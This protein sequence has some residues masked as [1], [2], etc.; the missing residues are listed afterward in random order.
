MSAFC[1]ALCILTLSTII[2]ITN[3][4]RHCSARSKSTAPASLMPLMDQILKRNSAPAPNT[5]SPPPS[6]PVGA[7]KAASGPG[8]REMRSILIKTHLYLKPM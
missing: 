7:T 6:A 8:M 1:S 3:V 5:V 4:P 2:S